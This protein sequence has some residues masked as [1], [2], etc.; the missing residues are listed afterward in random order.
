MSRQH[1]E[2]FFRMKSNP[3]DRRQKEGQKSKKKVVSRDKEVEIVFLEIFLVHFFSAMT[4]NDLVQPSI[5]RERTTE[6]P[7]D[8]RHVST[9]RCSSRCP[10]S[11]LS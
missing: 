7:G 8:Y 3:Y 6:F 10:V 9:D 2:L 5:Q 1:K 4:R 11:Y